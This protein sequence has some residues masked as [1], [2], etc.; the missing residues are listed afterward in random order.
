M[1][2]LQAFTNTAKL[3]IGDVMAISTKSDQASH[4]YNRITKKFD[5]FFILLQ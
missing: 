2:A 5:R 4:P 3:I 1:V